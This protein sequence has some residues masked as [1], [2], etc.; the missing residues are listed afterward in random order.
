MIRAL[1]GTDLVLLVGFGGR[2][3]PNQAKTR[4]SLGREEGGARSWEAFLTSWLP[5]E[6]HHSWIAT[7]E[8]RIQGLISARERQGRTAWEVNHLFLTEDGPSQA[9][10]LALLEHVATVP[11]E[12]V[13]K[14]FLRLPKENPLVDVAR[15]AGYFPYLTEFLYTRDQTPASQ[16]QL[17]VYP[18]LRRRAPADDPE[19]FR[20][21]QAA[22]PETVRRAEAMTYREWRESREEAQ[23]GKKDSVW[24]R[25]G[26]ITGWLRIT[27]AGGAR[28]LD[29]LAHPEE[30]EG[31][32]R[33]LD[34]GLARLAAKPSML[35]LV[36]EHQHRLTPLLESAGF[37]ATETYL[38]L[39]KQRAVRLPQRGLVPAAV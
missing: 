27:S 23:R 34:Y 13:E 32:S 37:V 5:L 15:R 30:E 25:E 11:E 2:A 12:R 26:S 20:L 35:C 9:V 19:L 39:V 3:L 38:V 29:L 21:Y 1:R 17:P 33:L 22:I 24:L 6:S 36:A 8:G 28:Q 31:L 10:C 18:N 14:V 16:T 7:E 4:Q